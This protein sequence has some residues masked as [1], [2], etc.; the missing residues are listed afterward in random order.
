[1][2][3]S[4]N[5]RLLTNPPR[6]FRVENIKKTNRFIK[7]IYS[8]SE[9]HP[10]VYWVRN[11]YL[12]S[13]SHLSAFSLQ[14]A[15]SLLFPLISHEKFAEFACFLGTT[16]DWSRIANHSTLWRIDKGLHPV[17]YSMLKLLKHFKFS[18]LDTGYLKMH[19]NKTG[20]IVKGTKVNKL[21]KRA[22]NM[23]LLPY[24]Y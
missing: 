13:G 7:K 11:R 24:R 22:R 6:H 3:V 9:P 21:I 1:V 14:T 4:L 5:R 10:D 8:S 15:L 23:G 19:L 16:C 18:Y 17:A 2:G 20:M 12:A